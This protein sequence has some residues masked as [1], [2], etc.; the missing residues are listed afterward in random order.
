MIDPT[1]DLQYLAWKA[2]QEERARKRG[3]YWLTPEGREEIREIWGYDDNDGATVTPL[4]NE[5]ERLEVQRDRLL[6]ACKAFDHYLAL[7]EADAPMH[8]TVPALLHA[9]RLTR[10]AIRAAEG[11]DS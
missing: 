9:T 10:A 2:E 3:R 8:E 7:V 1:A 5:V 11:E 4:L 6:A